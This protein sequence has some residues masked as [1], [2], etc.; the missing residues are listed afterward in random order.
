VKYRFKIWSEIDGKPLLGSG[1]YRLLSALKETGS[2]NAAAA[3]V[4]ISYRR[5]WA[6][7]REMERL[8]GYPLI[9]PQRGGKAGGGTE[10]TPD[11]L[12]LMKQYE[13]LCRKVDRALADS[14]AKVTE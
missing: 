4:G 14:G 11:A 3:E 8:L 7:I 6:Q 13:R 10:L 5:A 1:R 9:I 2:I 12:K